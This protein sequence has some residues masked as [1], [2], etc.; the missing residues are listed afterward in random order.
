[1]RPL[2]PQRCLGQ[3]PAD[4]SSMC[5]LPAFLTIPMMAR[6]GFSR[7]FA[8]GMEAAASSGGSIMPPVMGVAAFILASLT[9]VPYPR[10]S[11]RRRSRRCS[12]FLFVSE[13]G[14]SI[15]KAEHQGD[16]RSDR[17]HANKRSR[18]HLNL[19]MIFG[20]ILLILILLLTSKE[21]VGC[22]FIC[23]H[24][25]SGSLPTADASCIHPLG[26]RHFQNA[27]GDAG[28]TGWWADA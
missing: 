16:W 5:C 28:A 27:A 20:P 15:T 11:S 4:R 7:V 9:A 25:R 13:R 6:R 1:M 2:S 19:M 12:I 22:G 23:N 24:F 14:V 3:F 26:F 17:R 8:G 10:S 18:Y 21:D